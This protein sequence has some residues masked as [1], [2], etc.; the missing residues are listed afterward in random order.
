[1]N[2]TITPFN[3]HIRRLK[4]DRRECLVVATKVEGGQKYQHCIVWFTLKELLHAKPGKCAHDM[5]IRD[6]KLEE[7][8][9]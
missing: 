9:V 4:A 7:V 3:Q 8:R 6:E 1:M 2:D 5:W